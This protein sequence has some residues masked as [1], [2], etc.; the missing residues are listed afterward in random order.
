MKTSADQE[1]LT[2]AGCGGGSGTV[3]LLLSFCEENVFVKSLYI[4]IYIYT[5]LL[6]YIHT[7]AYIFIHTYKHTYIHTHTHIYIHTYIHTFIHTYIHTYIHTHIY[8]YIHTYTYTHTYIHTYTHTYIHTYI[9]TYTHIYTYI[10]TYTTKKKT[11]LSHFT[12]LSRDMWNS[13]AVFPNF[14]IFMYPTNSGGRLVRTYCA[15]WTKCAEK[16]FCFLFLNHAGLTSCI[17]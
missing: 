5:Y 4:Y 14:S 6:T 11:K 10:H 1:R 13:V 2:A 3:Q 12:C 16:R 7:H 9:H 17:T 15:A 8:T